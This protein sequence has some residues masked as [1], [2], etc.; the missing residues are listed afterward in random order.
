MSP[1][2]T[3]W[4]TVVIKALTDATAVDPS[5]TD[6]RRARHEADS[7]IRSGGKDYRRVCALAGLDPDFIREAYIDGRIDGA[8]LRAK[9]KTEA[10]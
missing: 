2:Q 5:S 4:Q 1:E 3:L 7:W 8:L 9:E 6:D 10:A